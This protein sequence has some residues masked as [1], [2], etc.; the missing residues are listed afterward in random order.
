LAGLVLAVSVSS[1]MAELTAMSNDELS[2]I[3]G[4]GIGVVFED[5]KFAAG[6]DEANGQIFKIG[7][8]KSSFGE[9]VEITVNQLFIAR[10]GSNRGQNLEPVNLGRLNNPFSIDV[11][12]GDDIGIPG[13]AVLELA[14]P[15]MVDPSVGFDCVSASAGAGSGPCSSRPASA[16]FEN[17]ERPDI[18]LQTNVQVGTKSSHNINIVAESAVIDGSRIR[19]WA[20]TDQNQLVSEIKLNFFT[21]RLTINACEVDGANCGS[22]I[23]IKD[24]RLELALGNRLQPTFLNVLGPNDADIGPIGNFVFEVSKIRQ[25]LPGEIGEDG[26]RSSSDTAAWD[27]YNDYY[28]NP[29][30]RSNLSIGELTIG[31]QNFGSAKVE[32]MLIQHLKITTHDLAPVP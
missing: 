19:L 10:S 14:A 3:N 23:N 16:S 20:D 24:F 32:G 4:Q 6:T 22:T 30:F 18:G 15:K 25:P 2:E 7:G 9:D 1:A 31:Q 5:F 21:P 13:K 29:E 28:T 26:L 17:G 12:D 8:I 11:L 27:F